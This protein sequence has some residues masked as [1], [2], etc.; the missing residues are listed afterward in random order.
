MLAACRSTPCRVSDVTRHPRRSPTQ[1]TFTPGVDVARA[2]GRRYD[3]KRILETAARA[4]TKRRHREAITCYRRVL[5]AEPQNPEIHRRIAPLLARTHQPFD[6][7]LSFRSAARALLRQGH[8]DRARGLYQE[9]VRHLPRN[10]EACLALARLEQKRGRP[11]RAFETLV[12]GSRRL[13]GRRDRPRA[14]HLLQIAVEIE[15]RDTQAALELARLLHRAR[16]PEEAR[17][18]LEGLAERAEGPERRRV[19]GTLLRLF[20]SPTSAWRWL[21]S[22]GARSASVPR[23][24]AR[25]RTGSDLASG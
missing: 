12:A 2:G 10:V 20:P 16:R 6:A 21:G 5:V 11:R 19:C 15:P 24:P 23:L 3:R 14:I 13:R 22:L 17:I 18:L 8:E 1:K 25:A 7:W 9:A 4:A